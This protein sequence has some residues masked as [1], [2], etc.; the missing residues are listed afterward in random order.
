MTDLSAFGWSRAAGEPHHPDCTRV[1]ADRGEKPDHS[2]SCAL[3]TG[4][5]DLTG[6]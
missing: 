6:R 2:G 1:R 4:H 3:V 5:P